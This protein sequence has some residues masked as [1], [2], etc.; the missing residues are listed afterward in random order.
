MNRELPSGRYDATEGGD[1]RMKKLFLL[2]V[3][4]AIAVFVAKQLAGNDTE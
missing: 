2:V 4:V 3:V 1:G